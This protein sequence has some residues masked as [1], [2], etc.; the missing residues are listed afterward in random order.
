MAKTYRILFLFLLI[1]YVGQCCTCRY[2]GFSYEFFKSLKHCFIGTVVKIDSQQFENKYTF[3]IIYTYKGKFD[4]IVQ[5]KSSNGGGD[6]G[7]TFELNK[8][9]LIDASFE[10]KDKNYHTS[11]CRFN[12]LKGTKEFSEDTMLLNLFSKKNIYINIANNKGQIRNGKP[13]GFWVVGGDSGVYKNGKINGLWKGSSSYETYYKNGKF[14]KT[15]DY[16]LNEQKTDSSKVIMGKRSKI[17]YY[18]NGKIHKIMNSR[19]LLIYYPNGI[20]KE[21]MTLNNHHYI[22]GNWYKYNE[23]GKLV[24]TKHIANDNSEDAYWHFENLE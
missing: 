1:N 17:L 8:T 20:L 9:Y 13:N 18:P 4:T 22:Y 3:R 23:K 2:E 19:K 7:E 10:K 24:E 14:I 21:K 12:A 16:V 11:Y 6:C 5:V 15:V